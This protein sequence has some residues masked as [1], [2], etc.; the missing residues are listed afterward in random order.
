MLLKYSCVFLLCS[1]FF[2]SGSVFAVE[3]TYRG[4]LIFTYKDV[5][6]WNGEVYARASH[7]KAEGACRAAE[8]KIK[9][10]AGGFVDRPFV[11]NNCINVFD[12]P[13]SKL[14][15]L[16]RETRNPNNPNNPA[17]GNIDKSKFKY[18]IA[19]IGCE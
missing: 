19:K 9:L 6:I 3:K 4:H 11:K 18:Q 13:K 16:A 5:I 10:C 15:S 12:E 8:L 2:A 1:F 14:A 17:N 7:Q